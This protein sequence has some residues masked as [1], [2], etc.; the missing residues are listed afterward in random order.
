MDNAVASEI[1][2]RLA[3]IP[4]FHSFFFLVSHTHTHT[5]THISSD[6]MLMFLQ[7]AISVANAQRANNVPCICFARVRFARDTSLGIHQQFNGSSQQFSSQLTHRC[8]NPLVNLFIC[9]KMRFKALHLRHYL[10]LRV[11]KKLS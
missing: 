4:M 2:S 11:I 6:E 10:Y 8:I 9:S 3:E 1:E 5:H 7:A